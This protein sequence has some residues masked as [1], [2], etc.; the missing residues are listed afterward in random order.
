[1]SPLVGGS[2]NRLILIISAILLLID[3]TRMNPE[4][5]ARSPNLE[6]LQTGYEKHV[7][8]ANRPK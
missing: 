2:L 3:H 8:C 6:F 7:H 1:M 5:K 4:T